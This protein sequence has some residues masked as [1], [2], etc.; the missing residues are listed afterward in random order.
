MGLRTLIFDFKFNENT[1]DEFIKE[2]KETIRFAGLTNSDT[3]S[4]PGEDKIEGASPDM[5]Q[6]MEA[7]QVTANSATKISIG[8]KPVGASI[9]VTKHCSMSIM[10]V[11]DVTQKGLDQ[12]VSYIKL[13]RD[14]FPKDEAEAEKVATAS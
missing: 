6:V 8:A 2:Y 5:E 7:Q 4:P 13:I 3:V 9:P 12:L 14:S 10:A 11:G 1:V